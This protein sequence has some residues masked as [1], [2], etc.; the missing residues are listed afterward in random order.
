VGCGWGLKGGER[1]KSGLIYEELWG[2]A[3]GEVGRR[4]TPGYKQG[5]SRNARRTKRSAQEKI[6]FWEAPRT[7]SKVGGTLSMAST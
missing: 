6:W 2:G 7:V 4:A 3:A 1:L 5:T